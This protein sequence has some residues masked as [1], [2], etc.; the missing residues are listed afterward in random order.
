LLR[1]IVNLRIPQSHYGLVSELMREGRVI[2]C[3]YE[4][5]DILM[6]VEIPAQL[7]AKVTPFLFG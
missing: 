3:E 2:A 6:Q 1:T 4:E 5:N 7:K